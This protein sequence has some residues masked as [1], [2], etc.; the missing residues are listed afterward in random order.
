MQE[1][2]YSGGEVRKIVMTPDPAAAD[3]F[4]VV[5]SSFPWANQS[6]YASVS[7][8]T[9][10]EVMD[11]PVVTCVLPAAQTRFLVGVEHAITARKFCLASKTSYLRG[12]K[13]F[14]GELPP[15]APR[16]ARIL[17]Y[18][19]NM[20]E[21][22]RPAPQGI[23]RFEDYY[24]AGEPDDV[25]AH[26]SLPRLRGAYDTYYG[27]TLVNGAVVRCKQYV[28]DEQTAYS[29]WDV[30]YWFRK[31]QMDAASGSN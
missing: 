15:W 7:T 18:G 29:D 19:I 28:Y 17:C 26:F 4:A 30:L 22:G 20:P 11:E 12:Y 6:D 1:I 13:L 21:F 10:H 25:E 16:S 5:K 31:K 8:A 2:Q 9:R 23:D 14:E 24:F 3:L 27:V